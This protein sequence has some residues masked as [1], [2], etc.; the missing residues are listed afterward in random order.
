MKVLHHCRE[1]TVVSGTSGQF[2]FHAG[3]GLGVGLPCLTASRRPAVPT[4]S[5]PAVTRPRDT[6]GFRER[7]TLGDAPSCGEIGAEVGT[8][9]EQ[10]GQV[11]NSKRSKKHGPQPEAPPWRGHQ[12]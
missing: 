5:P 10:A 2:F 9:T 12:E 7:S 4:D 6:R 1:S 11:Y 3:G 8:L